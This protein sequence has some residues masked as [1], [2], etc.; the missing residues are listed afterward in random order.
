MTKPLTYEEMRELAE[1]R[2]KENAFNALDRLYAENDEALRRLAMN[3]SEDR[4]D[5]PKQETKNPDEIIVQDIEMFHMEMMN[6]DAM[7]IGITRKN[8]QI[9]HLNIITKGNK[10]SVLWTP[11]TGHMNPIIH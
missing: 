10:L 3:E 2:E 5:F 1:R 9:D 7:W 8:G 4:T 11:A 6:D